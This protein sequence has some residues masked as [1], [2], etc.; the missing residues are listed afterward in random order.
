MQSTFS[1]NERVGVWEPVDNTLFNWRK[2][3]CWPQKTARSKSQ[4]EFCLSDGYFQPQFPHSQMVVIVMLCQLIWNITDEECG[5]WQWFQHI[6]LSSDVDL[7]FCICF[8]CLTIWFPPTNLNSPPPPPPI[9]M[10]SNRLLR[11]ASLFGHLLGWQVPVV[12]VNLSGTG[13]ISKH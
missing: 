2:R 10:P 1:S 3:C 7:S 12:L 9:M 6:G 8:F 4:L 5:I 13:S 11:N